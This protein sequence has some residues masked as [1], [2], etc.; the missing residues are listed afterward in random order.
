MAKLQDLKI[1]M[2]SEK[3]YKSDFEKEL[4]IKNKNTPTLENR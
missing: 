1:T 4:L 2:E 3:T